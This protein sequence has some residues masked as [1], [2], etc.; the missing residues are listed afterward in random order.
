ML[1]I[2]LDDQEIAAEDEDEDDDS[3]SLPSHAE[4]SINVSDELPWNHRRPSSRASSPASTVSS[5]I[6]ATEFRLEEDELSPLHTRLVHDNAS[7]KD[8]NAIDEGANGPRKNDFG[9]R[10]MDINE[11]IGSENL[12]GVPIEADLNLDE[13]PCSLAQQVKELVRI[14]FLVV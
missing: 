10:T 3:M 6:S 5:G 11:R 4:D 2:I 8:E 12:P 1:P 7:E 13:L 9:D 14:F